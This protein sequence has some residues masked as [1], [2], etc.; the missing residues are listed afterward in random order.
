MNIEVVLIAIGVGLA[1][2]AGPVILLTLLALLGERGRH[3]ADDD[4]LA[5][6]GHSQREIAG[7]LGV[8]QKTVSND[9]RGEE[10]SSPEPITEPEPEEVS[11]PEPIAVPEPAKP[12]VGNNSGDNDE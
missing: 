6:E 7:V 10:V 11:S 2:V 8:D 4:E 9:W 3:R 1:V 12:H 5:S